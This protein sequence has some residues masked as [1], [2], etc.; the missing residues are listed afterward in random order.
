MADT[1][2]V[3]LGQSQSPGEP[4]VSEVDIPANLHFR[5]WGPV[6]GLGDIHL[7]GGVTLPA[8]GPDVWAPGSGGPPTPP[9][10]E[11]PKAEDNTMLYIAAAAALGLVLWS[12]TR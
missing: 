9:S 3:F 2:Y 10:S 11:P 1:N 5:R 4:G 12:S 8:P 6:N 7:P